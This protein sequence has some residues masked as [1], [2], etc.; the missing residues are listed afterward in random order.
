MERLAFFVQ[1]DGELFQATSLAHPSS[2]ASDD[3]HPRET[4]VT[5]TTI[6]VRRE[7]QTFIPLPLSTASTGQKTILFGVRTW[8]QP[9]TAL[10]T[11]E[12][13]ALV[14]IAEGWTEEVARYKGRDGWLDVVR[15]YLR[16]R[17]LS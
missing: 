1:T 3:L 12:I 13:E 10:R 8:I 4:E 17:K 5:P 9:L 6:H 16:E 11:D 14:S 7:R 2:G 15:R